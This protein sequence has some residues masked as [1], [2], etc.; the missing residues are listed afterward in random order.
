MKYLTKQKYLFVSKAPGV[1]RDAFGVIEFKGYESLSKPYRFEI[2]LISDAPETDPGL[3]LQN[4]AV[5]TI[6]RDEGDDVEF[7]GILAE[8]AEIQEFGGYFFFRAVLVPKLW[9]LGLTHHNQV[10][11]ESTIPE[12]MESALKDG[13]LFPGIDFEFRVQKD[14]KRLE[15]VCQYDESHFNFVSRLAEKEGI[16]Y[17]FEQ[18]Q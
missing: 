15:Y 9:W 18:V 11:L 5:F 17:F 7:N 2:D 6:C 16:Y 1:A 14:Y 10:F 8:F 4:P 12:I 13:G 3:V